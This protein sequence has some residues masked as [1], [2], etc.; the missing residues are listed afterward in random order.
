MYTQDLCLLFTV[1]HFI[2]TKKGKQ[3]S[4]PLTTDRIKK[5]RPMYWM[6]YYTAIKKNEQLINAIWM[7]PQIWSQTKKSTYSVF[8]FM[9]N[10]KKYKQIC[11]R[12]RSM[13]VWD[14]DREKPDGG[15]T[16]EDTKIFGDNEYF[17]YL[18]G[19]EGLA[20]NIPRL[21]SYQSI[22]FKYMLFIVCQL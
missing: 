18:K 21:K 6:K 22:H 14:G 15:I 19:S 13:V 1:H 20:V 12:K 17:Y 5:L 7:N 11:G 10:S 2:T 16:T 9:S 4:L 3:S 8:S